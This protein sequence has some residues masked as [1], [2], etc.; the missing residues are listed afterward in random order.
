MPRTHNAKTTCRAEAEIWK[1]VDAPKLLGGEDLGVSDFVK[2]FQIAV[3]E[4]LA[5]RSTA[6]SPC[7]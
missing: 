7:S 3:E 4:M 1:N 6:D 5:S 2:I